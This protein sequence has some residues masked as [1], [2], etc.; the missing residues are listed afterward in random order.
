MNCQEL[1]IRSFFQTF[2]QPTKS[3]FE[4]S[5]LVYGILPRLAL[6]KQ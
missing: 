5:K 2:I 1:L 6:V 3:K 4:Y